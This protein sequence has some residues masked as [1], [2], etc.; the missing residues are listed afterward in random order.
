MPFQNDMNLCCIAEIKKDGREVSAFLL[1]V[2]K[3]QYQFVFA[4]QLEGLH[5]LLTKTEIVAVADAL[6]EGLKYLPAGERMTFCTGCYSNDT[7]R[8]QDLEALA[9]ICGFTPISVLLRNEQKRLQELTASGK[10][11]VWQQYV[12]CT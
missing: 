4:F 3:H 8:Q 12:F 10:R 1:E 11:Q 9:D 7:L 2:G 5:D 6:E